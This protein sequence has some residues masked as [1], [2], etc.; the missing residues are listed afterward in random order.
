MKQIPQKIKSNRSDLEALVERIADL[1]D[2]VHRALGAQHKSDVSA[3][4]KEDL[5]RFNQYVSFPL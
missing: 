3:G 5:L 1:L 4:L 2:P